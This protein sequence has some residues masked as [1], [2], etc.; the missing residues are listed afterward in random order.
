MAGEQFRVF[1]IRTQPAVAARSR[2]SRARVPLVTRALVKQ[3][4]TAPRA[5]MKTRK[6]EG[7]VAARAVNGKRWD[8]FYSRMMMIGS[9]QVIC[10]VLGAVSKRS[11]VL[12]AT[13]RVTREEHSGCEI[14]I[15]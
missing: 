2:S 7:R 6:G 11:S 10:N 12:R 13:L 9:L 5:R 1:D 8:P 4:V 3:R 15:E 14:T